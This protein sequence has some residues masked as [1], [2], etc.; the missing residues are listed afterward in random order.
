MEWLKF[1]DVHS[2]VNDVAVPWLEMAA[3]SPV[4]QGIVGMI[5]ALLSVWLLYVYFD[6]RFS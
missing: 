5:S 1:P 3:A 4:G 6:D 2:W